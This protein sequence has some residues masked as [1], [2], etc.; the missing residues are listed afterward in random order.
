MRYRQDCSD[1]PAFYCRGISAGHSHLFGSGRCIECSF[2]FVALMVFIACHHWVDERDEA[3]LPQKA[4]YHH[5]KQ[6]RRLVDEQFSVNSSHFG[7]VHHK[8]F[9][10][11]GLE[12]RQPR[13]A[14]CT[15]VSVPIYGFLRRCS[16]V[17]TIDCFIGRSSAGKKNV[18]GAS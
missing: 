9:A 1:V 15:G 10:L 6:L 2:L 13:R 12:Y 16:E 7:Q 5:P 14:R 3:Q 17:A 8:E 18:S 4:H 11:C